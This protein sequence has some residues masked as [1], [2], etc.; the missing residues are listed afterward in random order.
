MIASLPRTARVLLLL[1]TVACGQA[2]TTV[3][4]DFG[5]GATPQFA[6][7]AAC[8]PGQPDRQPI[9][10]DEPLVVLVHGC[11]SSGGRFRSLAQVFEFHG[12]QALCFNYDDRDSLR[13]SG[14]QLRDALRGIGRHMRSEEVTVLGHSQGGLISRVALSGPREPEDSTEADRYR[15]VTVS[16]PFAG[17]QAASD[18][19]SLLLHVATLGITVAACQIVT[20]SDWNEIH[21]GAP[22]VLDP[23]PLRP[24]VARHLVVMTDERES[25]REMGPNGAC[26]RDDFVFGV[27][28]QDNPRVFA[29]PRVESDLVR[30]GH[31][32]I[33]GEAGDRP[34]KLVEALQ[35][36]GIL[37]ATPPD[38]RE[39]FAALVRRLF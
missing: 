14:E 25:C 21:P 13:D 32:E 7:L 35:R 39:E 1:S 16:S 30:A 19:G 24:R 5:T 34:Q 10:P 2:S 18:C 11:Y 9:D 15:L 36:H 6:G 23:A 38:K 22:M 28:E 27:D 4:L 29:D 37:A 26:E 3:P 8:S 31:V 12:Q 20:G 17:I 33:V